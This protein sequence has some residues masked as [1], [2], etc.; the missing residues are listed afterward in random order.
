[1]TDLSPARADAIASNGHGKRIVA[2]YDYRDEQGDLLL[3]AVR[4]DPQGFAQRRPDGTGDWTW[5]LGDVRR[6]LYRLPELLAADPDAWVLIV[7]GEKDADRLAGLGFLATT[8]AAG[9]GKWRPE[10]SEHL[11]DRRVAII[12]DNDIPGGRHAV[13]VAQSLDGIARTVRIVHLPDLEPKGDA[14]D[15][16]DAG[17]TT[18]GLLELIEDTLDFGSV[19]DAEPEAPAATDRPSARLVV[20]SL[21]SVTPTETDWLWRHWLARG[22]FHLLGGHAGDGK[23]TIMAALAAIGSVGGVW[24]DG[25]RA[26][27]F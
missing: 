20:R 27:R 21:S 8:N 17:G 16:L 5:T 9:V 3:Q 11:R 14:S 6:V 25:T 13:K 26:P 22:K 1:M 12:P 23:S 7:E 15:W 2:E 4:F 18:D 19:N 24:P 10:Y